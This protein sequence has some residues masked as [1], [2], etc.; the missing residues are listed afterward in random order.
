MKNVAGYDALKLFIGAWGTLGVLTEVTL[1]LFP[2]P[3][4]EPRAEP[5]PRPFAPTALER[6]LKRALDPEGILNNVFFEDGHG[7]A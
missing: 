4:E 1:R 6:R 7:R 2:F 3:P 5:A